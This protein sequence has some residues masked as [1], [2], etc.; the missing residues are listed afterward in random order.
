MKISKNLSLAIT[1]SI[2]A[3]IEILKIYNQKTVDF[4]LKSDNSPLTLAD[5]TANNIIN[6]YLLKTQIPIISEE[7]KSVDYEIRKNWKT[8]WMIDPLDGTKEFINKNGEFTVNISLIVD[9]IPTIGVVFAPFLGEIYYAEKN[10]GSFKSKFVSSNSLS[11][12]NLIKN[13]IKLPIHNKRKNYT[14]VVSRS[15]LDKNT[16][17]FIEEKKRIYKDVSIVK[18]G[19]SI[20]ICKIAEGVADCYP[21]FFPLMEWDIAAGIAIYLNSPNNINSMTEFNFNSQDLK[22]NQFLLEK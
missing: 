11:L 8:F 3:G 1:A 4:E 10:L 6:K 14:I 13:S 22:I 15:H 12:K 18:C 17:K 16:L 20:K 9:N 7:N 5:I 21:R 19:S 2:D